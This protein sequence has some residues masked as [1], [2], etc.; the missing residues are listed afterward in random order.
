MRVY[1]AEQSGGPAPWA[2]LADAWLGLASLPFRAGLNQGSTSTWLEDTTIK[3]TQIRWQLEHTGADSNLHLVSLAKADI[4][5]E[6]RW[7]VIQV[8]V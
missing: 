7:R 3:R 1:E 8:N 2:Q 4:Q 6:V 5:T